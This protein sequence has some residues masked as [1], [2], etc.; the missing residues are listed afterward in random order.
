ME[1]YQKILKENSLEDLLREAEEEKEIGVL[2]KP[3]FIYVPSVKLYFEDKR[4]HIGKNWNKTHE[5]L[6]QE[7]LFMPTPYQFKKFLRYLRDTKN[8]LYEEITEARFPWRANWLNARFG[9]KENGLYMISENVVENGNYKTIEIKLKDVLM[10][11]I[12]HR[13]NL[14]E[15]LDSDNSHGLPNL[16]ISHGDLI[17]SPMGI[18]QVSRFS[19]DSDL[20]YLFCNANPDYFNS[21]I[22]VFACCENPKKVLNET[23]E[24][25]LWQEFLRQNEPPYCA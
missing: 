20:T 4:T 21:S 19:V 1:F 24:D 11:N 8:P 6:K 15:W 14:N 22:G 7:G 9:K 25:K 10:E 5:L 2:E 18:D 17:Y 16:N 12:S 3:G 13:I 23:K